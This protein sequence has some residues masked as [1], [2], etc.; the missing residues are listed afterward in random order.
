MI[1]AAGVQPVN[2]AGTLLNLKFRAKTNQDHNTLV[3]LDIINPFI[4]DGTSFVNGTYGSFVIQNVVYGDVDDNNAVQAYDAAI[5]LQYS[6]M[7][8]PL[9]TIDPLPW[10][11]WRY[12]RAD[13]SGDGNVYA[14]D[15]SLILQYSI[16][17]INQFPVESNRTL[18]YINPQDLISIRTDQSRIAVMAQNLDMIKGLNIELPICEQVSYG[19]IEYKP[20]TN[21]WLKL[22]NSTSDKLMIALA[23][24]E[25]EENNETLFTMNYQ[26][27]AICTMPVKV[28][29][30]DDSMTVNLSLTPLANE[31]NT[32]PL[33]NSVSK[34]YPNPFNPTTSIK[35]SVKSESMVNVEIYNIKGQKVKTLVKEK[36]TAGMHTLIWNGKDDNGQDVSTGIYF[37]RTQIGNEFKQ[38]HK[39]LLMK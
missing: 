26:T 34:N 22:S 37:Y 17:L 10:S 2:G 15:A 12:L 31:D 30:N 32:L 7:M 4:N 8:D 24:S 9:P 13:V 6:V 29:V 39:M 18:D 3:Y 21:N 25:S 1:G 11:D 16:D 38:T 35:L 19:Q 5:T 23:N 20:V 28:I 33:I 14:Y 27:D 36:K